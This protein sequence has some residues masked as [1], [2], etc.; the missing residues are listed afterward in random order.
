[1]SRSS[2][3]TRFRFVTVTAN[4]A[5]DLVFDAP[6][7]ELGSHTPVWLRTRQPAGKGIN[8]SLALSR[9]NVDSVATGFVGA[10]LFDAFESH[11]AKGAPGNITSQLLI[12][13][14][15]TRQNTTLIDTERH[16][17]THLREQG[18]PLA[19]EQTRALTDRIAMLASPGTVVAICGSLPPGMT[20]SHV[21]QMVHRIHHGGGRVALDL[22]GQTL[23]QIL[24]ELASGW[25]NSGPSSNRASAHAP[26]QGSSDSASRASQPS[27]EASSGARPSASSGARSE[28]FIA[29]SAELWSP[30]N[31]AS[32][33][34]K[35]IWLVSPNLDEAIEA[36]QAM[37]S[38]DATQSADAMHSADATPSSGNPAS[39]KHTADDALQAVH[40]WRNL[41]DWTLLS[42]GSQG[43]WLIGEDQAARGHLDI[44]PDQ[45]VSTVGC[46]DCL[47]AG[48][49]AG[50][51]EQATALGPSEQDDQDE[52][53]DQD[54]QDE[55]AGKAGQAMVMAALKRGLA[56][57]SANLFSH[58][59]AD[60]SPAR[61]TRLECQC[62]VAPLKRRADGVTWV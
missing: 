17:D 54:E 20:S 31:P 38:A 3:P 33:S 7:L 14:A 28:P 6:G 18:E 39:G 45:I 8:V 56:M 21:V 37:H 30:S 9:A 34:G 16:L 59:I 19:D 60:F 43:A 23:G 4:C 51:G 1:M 41:V 15:R 27:A 32:A 61:I 55:P 25:S 44:N 29:S 48:V 58:G 26:P 57:A 2:R 52:Q 40:A 49:L 10:D 46:G 22:P 12:G 24:R 11:L 35:P 42:A 47:L 53:G 5:L 36:H 13:P 50:L 62:E